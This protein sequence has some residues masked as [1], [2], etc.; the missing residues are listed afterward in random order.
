M[1]WSKAVS[2]V[3]TM[4]SWKGRRTAVSTAEKTVTTLVDWTVGGKDAGLVGQT[5]VQRDTA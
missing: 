5:V 3:Q 1:V 4:A 2:W